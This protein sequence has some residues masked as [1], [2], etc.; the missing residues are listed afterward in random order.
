MGKT[1]AADGATVR[2]LLRNT[3]V[4][5]G[6]AVKA[7]VVFQIHQL[8]KLLVTKRASKWSDP[9]MNSLMCT[10]NERIRKDLFAECACE[11]L[12]LI[13]SI[14]VDCSCCGRYSRVWI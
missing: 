2:L 6:M 10:K 14:V 9:H 11:L 13:A 7:V 1:L 3:H 8:E 12:F 4:V 5:G